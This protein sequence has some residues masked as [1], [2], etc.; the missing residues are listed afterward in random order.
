MSLNL[1]GRFL[2]LERKNKKLFVSAFFLQA[3]IRLALWVVPFSKLQGFAFRWPTSDCSG[4]V[5]EN[6]VVWAVNATS[7]LVPK[8]TCF[9]R[10][11]AAQVLLHRA[12]FESKLRIGVAKGAD[13]ELEGHAWVERGSRV[14][15]GGSLDLF[16]YTLLPFQS[17]KESATENES[18]KRQ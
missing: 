10:A 13:G 9:V 16:R 3:A 15:M 12:G 1:I 5:G 11:L 17:L 2:R 14:V 6:R 4:P 7:R 18:A 8:C